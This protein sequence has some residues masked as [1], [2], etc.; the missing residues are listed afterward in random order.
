VTKTLWEESYAISDM[1]SSGEPNVWVKELTQDLKA[2]RLLDVAGGEGRNA[3]WLAH[4]GWQATIIDSSPV[5]LCRAV[6]SAAELGIDS[7]RVTIARAD[8]RTYLPAR[9][10][11]DLVLI[12]YL[13][14]SM[15]EFGSVLRLAASAVAPG[16]QLLVIGHDSSNVALEADEMSLARHFFSAHEVVHELE[17]SGL[18]I[19]HAQTRTRTV[20]EA[21]GSR[22]AYDVVVQASRPLL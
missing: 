3:I 15:A 8:A 9:H 5:A 21:H 14:L 19:D 11:Y 4:R 7:A 20:H 12:S 16:G 10:G 1:L 2:G 13:H 18:L 6:H 22:P 17:G